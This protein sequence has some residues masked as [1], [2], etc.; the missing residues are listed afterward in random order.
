MDG[1]LIFP[2]AGGGISLVVSLVTSLARAR[3]RAMALRNAAL[4]SSLVA[5]QEK[6]TLAV[7]TELRGHTERL[8]VILRGYDRGWFN[9]G[10]RIDIDGHGYIPASIELSG[11][12]LDST[13]GKALGDEALEIGDPAFDRAV[14]V[15]GPDFMLLPLLD[16]ETRSTLRTVVAAG[17]RTVNGTIR[18]EVNTWSNAGRIASALAMALHAARRLRPPEDPVERLVKIADTDPC[19]TVRVRCLDLLR[20]DYAQDER[21]RIAFRLALRS[22]DAETRLVGAIGLA[23]DGQAAL[24]DIASDASTE[25]PLAVRA[26]A[27]LGARLAPERT[28]SIL[29]NAIQGQRFAVALAAIQALRL[30]GGPLA[31]S[32]LASL[33]TADATDLAVTAATALASIGDPSAEAPLIAALGSTSNELRLAAAQ[34]LGHV[35]TAVSVAPLHAAADGHL[36]DLGLRSAAQHAIAAIQAR[37][38]GASPGQMSLA[39]GESGQVSLADDDASGR[40]SVPREPPPG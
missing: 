2:I 37:A 40:L 24:I 36:L 16:D 19:P 21:A 38:R 9:H 7:V 1:N 25:E 10:T 32:R 22:T 14:H 5:I 33:L 30:V 12:G 15:R 34:A 17:G 8:E 26:I 11:W 3:G 31:V 28:A 35:G 27:A 6:R 20:R 23:D 29:D 18:I 13:V 4:A 39:E